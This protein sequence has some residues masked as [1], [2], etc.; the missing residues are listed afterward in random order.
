MAKDL[1]KMGR[2]AAVII[3]LSVIVLIGI[4]VFNVFG[5]TQ[6]IGANSTTDDLTMGAVNTTTDL[7]ANFPFVTNVSGCGNKTG[8]GQAMLFPTHYSISRGDDT[9]GGIVLND[10]G[11]GFV[12]AVVNCTKI[13]YLADTSVS[14]SARAFRTGIIIFGTFLSV[15]VLALIGKLVIDLFMRKKEE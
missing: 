8:D 4:A 14:I 13:N 11:G 7:G 3:G 12:G 9:G 15:I 10:V 1:N 6:R 2:D 5:E